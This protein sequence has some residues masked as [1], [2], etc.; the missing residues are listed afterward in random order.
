MYPALARP[1]ATLSALLSLPVIAL[2]TAP[3]WPSEA[4]Q[5]EG[6][7]IVAVDFRALA[8]DGT[9]VLDLKPEEIVLKVGG[10]VRDIMALELM[11]AVSGEKA[12]PKA[13]A[14]MP[15]PFVTNS[16]PA[17]GR[18]VMLVVDEEAIA[19]G[20]EAP[21]RNALGQLVSALSPVDRVG[22]LPVR[23][24]AGNAS[25]T[26]R[27][28]RVLAAIA[29]LSARATRGETAADA[30]C[31]TRTNL[32]ALLGV[33][34]SVA[35][36][37][38]TAVVFVS[39][40]FTPPTVIENIARAGGPA[41]PCEI[42][43]R[44][45][46]NLT[47]IVVASR[48]HFFVLQVID[49][50]MSG[51]ATGSEMTG[52][53]EHVAGLTGNAVIRLIGESERAIKRIASETSAYYLAAF[54]VSAQERTG[55]THRVEVTVTRQGVEVRAR[56]TLVIPKA[57][58][59]PAKAE[60]LKPRDMLALAKVFRTLPLRARAYTSRLS[61][62][63]KLKVVVVFEPGDSSVR[64]T[65]AAVALFDG[66]GKARAQWTGQPGELKQTPVIAALNGPA[67][68]S[69]RVRV[70]AVDASG[71]GGTVDQ[72]ITVEIAK[73]GAVSVGELVLGAQSG[74]SFTPRLQFVDEP[75]AVALVE[76]VGPP[77]TATVSAN[78]ELAGSEDGPA[79]GTL[80]GT[81]PAPREG[82]WT[83]FVAFPIGP[84]PPG[85]V[86]VRAVI[87]VDGQPVAARPVRT[88]RKVAR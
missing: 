52:G 11:R 45:L 33:F 25:P 19:L 24:G 42:T 13:P 60:S 57:G 27:H 58:A 32:H 64:F 23:G 69:Y 10:R 8:R 37:V 76:I 73:Q 15:P 2:T 31:R 40:G 34:E 12:S 26:T 84:M 67:A 48:A 61:P 44:D 18:E 43:P 41:G 77:K 47:K 5:G 14:P 9:P 74:N 56:P 4:K 71:D 35:L 36:S 1:V 75:A 39:N 30:A 80:A 82:L 22:V 49:D 53:L 59:R 62:D 66:G 68:G 63:G 46:E 87:S 65:E 28:D 70:A 85:D 83:A 3:W 54:E 81:V 51:A 20:G 88:L 79:L 50:T 17:G 72:D 6:S 86:V 38:P 78:F 21:V 16:P 55:A 29:A 7:T